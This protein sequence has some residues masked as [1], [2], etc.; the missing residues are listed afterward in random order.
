MK[1]RSRQ[2]RRAE[3]DITR[4]LPKVL[5]KDRD[6]LGPDPY[7]GSTFDFVPLGLKV[8]LEEPDP[9]EE[10]RALDLARKQIEQQQRDEHEALKKAIPDLIRLERYEHR[11][12]SRQQRA[13]HPCDA[14]GS[15]RAR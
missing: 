6:R 12:W 5:E 2:A 4:L 10:E 9:L 13:I 14:V 3:K 8:L 15:A 1:A 7:C 11:A